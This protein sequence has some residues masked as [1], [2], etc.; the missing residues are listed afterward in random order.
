MKLI[1]TPKNFNIDIEVYIRHTLL[2]VVILCTSCRPVGS[3]AGMV[4][5]L[6]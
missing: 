6:L 5:L 2:K 4:S 1:I 3:L